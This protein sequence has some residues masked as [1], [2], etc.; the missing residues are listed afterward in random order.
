MYIVSRHQNKRSRWS[1]MVTAI[2]MRHTLVQKPG[3]RSDGNLRLLFTEK[4]GNSSDDGFLIIFDVR[5]WV[6]S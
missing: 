3:L 2:A 5:C 4:E 1:D 6:G